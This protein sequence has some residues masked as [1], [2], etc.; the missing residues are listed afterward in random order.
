[1]KNGAAIVFSPFLLASNG[2]VATLLDAKY[3]QLSQKKL[4]N[5]SI[6][7]NRSDN[8]NFTAMN[9]AMSKVSL[10]PFPKRC[11]CA[12]KFTATRSPTQEEA[13][14]M[15]T[16]PISPAPFHDLYR[17]LRLPEFWLGSAAT[18]PVCAASRGLQPNI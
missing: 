2:P 1:V 12:I 14:K 16:R 6:P 4:I 18:I 3:L 10:F 5:Y 17:F 8:P 11:F 7:D 13:Q 15:R 9:G